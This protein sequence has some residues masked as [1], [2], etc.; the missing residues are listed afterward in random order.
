MALEQARMQ[1]VRK[2]GGATVAATRSLGLLRALADSDAAAQ[3]LSLS[4]LP[5]PAVSPPPFMEA[6]S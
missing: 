6:R 5:L 1:I 3:A 4:T 2:P